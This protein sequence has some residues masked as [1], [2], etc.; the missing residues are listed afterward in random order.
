M[1]FRWFL[2]MVC[3]FCSL[4]ACS[5]DEE[6]VEIG[7]KGKARL[8]PWLAAERF[9]KADG[10]EVRSL[11]SWKAP[12]WEDAVIFMPA[13]NLD[14]QSVIR[15]TESW[16]E[17]GGHLVLLVEHAD[18][19]R[20]DWSIR[21]DLGNA[22]GAVLKDWLESAGIRC[23]PEAGVKA[24]Q[25]EYE[26][27]V[28]KISADSKF[29]VAVGDE[30]P[31][32][33]A[34]V[35]S[36]EGRI[37]VLT[38]ARVL[39]NRWMADHEHAALLRA[40]VDAADYEGAVVFMRGGGVS[41]WGLLGRYL[42]PVL[43]GLGVFLVLWLWK[44]FSRFGPLEAAGEASPLRGYDHHL[45]ALGDYQWRLDRGAAL[46]QPLRERIIEQGQRMCV[47][48]GLRDDDF[49]Q[50]LADRAGLPRERVMRALAE[51]APADAAV[52]TRTSADLQLLLQVLH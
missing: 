51:P 30:E 33:L 37:T 26:E 8:N 31:G 29:G 44:N 19:E 4:T 9:T 45:E 24:K 41:F 6:E 49:F 2:V 35:M 5:Y 21:R 18:A 11:P 22:P 28:F 25:V 12:E 39:R 34:T 42:W 15:Q 14:N 16:V 32:V 10:H 52:L 20:G 46:L 7:H 38:D 40:L 13:T 47:R 17:D 50:V 36:G 23:H 27:V 3:A 43:I 48:A 1:I